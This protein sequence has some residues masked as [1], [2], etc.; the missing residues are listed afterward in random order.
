MARSRRKSRSPF[1]LRYLSERQL[2]VFRRAAREHLHAHATRPA[3]RNVTATTHEVPAGTLA[4]LTFMSAGELR[5]PVAVRLAAQEDRR[6]QLHDL[7]LLP[8]A[9]RAGAKPGPAVRAKRGGARNVSHLALVPEPSDTAG[10]L[11]A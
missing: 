8:S 2:A 6:E 11:G 7:A 5:D 9:G 4:P 3:G 10:N 1:P